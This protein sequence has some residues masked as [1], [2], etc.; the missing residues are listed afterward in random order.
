MTNGTLPPESPVTL[1]PESPVLSGNK[2]TVSQK[3]RVDI[4]CSELIK[5]EPISIK[6]GVHVLEETLI[7]TIQKLLHL[8][9]V[10]AALPR[11]IWSDRLSR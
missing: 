3:K 6:N 2:Y 5:Y 10:L 9:Y 11:E 4:F 8:K 1:P 7:K